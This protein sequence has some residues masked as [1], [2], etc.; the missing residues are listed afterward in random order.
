M[1]L[2]GWTID[3]VSEW[4]SSLSFLGPS[5]SRKIEEECI[6]G[7]CFMA[8][9]DKVVAVS[10]SSS[11]SFHASLGVSSTGPILAALSAQ[12]IKSSS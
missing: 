11:T 5:I 6:D 10:V 12:P 1:G 9:T 3:R 2:T 7:D 8:L 4:I